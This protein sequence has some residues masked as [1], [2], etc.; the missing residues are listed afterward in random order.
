MQVL[1]YRNKVKEKKKL[2]ALVEVKK[3]ERREKN[4][5]DDGREIALDFI[6]QC[7]NK[8][9]FGKIALLF[10]TEIHHS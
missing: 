3:R 9:F 1:L 6:E 2:L 8:G 10:F 5:I 4:S 7:I